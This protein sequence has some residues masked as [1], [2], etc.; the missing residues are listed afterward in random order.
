L[1]GKHDRWEQLG[2]ETNLVGSD[3]QVWLDAVYGK[4][5][6]G[7]AMSLLTT[8]NDPALGISRVFMCNPDRKPYTNAS[9]FCDKDLD[10]QWVQAAQAPQDERAA[11]YKGII[12]QLH[13]EVPAV[14]LID[15]TGT[16]VINKRFGNIDAFFDSAGHPELHW[17]KLTFEN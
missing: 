13:E 14:P 7:A 2:V 3:L 17:E 1:I 5:E 10:A 11:I 9:G 8:R 12:A 4:S 6:F 16:D 15:L